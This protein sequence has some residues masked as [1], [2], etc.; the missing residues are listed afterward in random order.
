MYEFI[1]FMTFVVLA[2]LVG[3]FAIACHHRKNKIIEGLIRDGISPLLV[4]AAFR[5]QCSFEDY[6]SWKVSGKDSH[7]LGSDKTTD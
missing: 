6:I 2:F 1:G 7:L 4:K 5:D 3:I